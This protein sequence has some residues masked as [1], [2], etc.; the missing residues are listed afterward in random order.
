MSAPY[1]ETSRDAERAFYAAFRQANLEEMMQVWA[2]DDSIMC[3]HPMGPR[4]DGRAAVTRSWEQIFSGGA[5]M[6]FEL[7]EVSCTLNGDLAV[8]CVYENI[9]HGPHGP[10]FG[11][12]SLVLATNIYKSTEQG[13]RMLLHHG[14]P[15]GSLQPRDEEPPSTL[16]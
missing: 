5:A 4:L 12:R 10:G 1:Y 7:S 8:H 6:R 11:Q 2:D 15:G 16:H 14:S 9:D 13:W 3:I